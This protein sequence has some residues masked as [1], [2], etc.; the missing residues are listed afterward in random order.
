MCHALEVRA[1]REAHRGYFRADLEDAAGES[2]SLSLDD[3]LVHLYGEKESPKYERG[4][5]L[6]RAAHLTE[7]SPSLR[8]VAKVTTS[9]RGTGRTQ[10]DA[11]LAVCPAFPLGTTG[12]RRR[13]ERGDTPTTDQLRGDSCRRGAAGLTALSDSSSSPALGGGRAADLNAYGCSRAIRWT[14]SLC[15]DTTSPFRSRYPSQVKSSVTTSRDDGRR[16]R[17]GR[18]C[19][20]SNHIPSRMRRARAA[21]GEEPRYQ[22]LYSRSRSLR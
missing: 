1:C 22:R 12:T 19:S 21:S 13:G 8:D 6:A 15:G 7:G 9:S 4:V 16:Q 2:S 5:A 18:P 10:L 20:L 3:H 14:N 11:G 17:C